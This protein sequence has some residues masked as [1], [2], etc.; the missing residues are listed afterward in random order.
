[1]SAV[2]EDS[3][4]FVSVV[5]REDYEKRLERQA[6]D[7]RLARV[8]VEAA[9]I[10]KDKN[11][12]VEALKAAFN[13]SIVSKLEFS[14]GHEV[15]FDPRRKLAVALEIL[16]YANRVAKE[17]RLTGV[18]LG[19]LCGRVEQ[20]WKNTLFDPDFDMFKVLPS[21]QRKTIRS[22]TK[23]REKRIKEF[24]TTRYDSEELESYDGM[25]HEIV[26][27]KNKF[28]VI[29]GAM[30]SG[31]TTLLREVQSIYKEK[32]YFPILIT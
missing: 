13:Y 27:T 30:A 25:A 11:S 16:V 6:Q 2:I 3:K 29:N 31:K 19:Y 32:R 21:G 26:E 22:R 15:V 1:M 18:A 10:S 8:K 9:L 7:A 20:E 24:H 12:D 14:D 23:N 28:I 5:I 17:P 4:D